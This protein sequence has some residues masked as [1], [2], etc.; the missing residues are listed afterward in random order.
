M[1]G[2]E[3][4]ELLKTGKAISDGEKIYKY[5]QNALKE[6]KLYQTHKWILSESFNLNEDYTEY[7]LQPTGWHSIGDGDFFTVSYADDVVFMHSHRADGFGDEDRFTT[8]E[9]AE[10]IRFKNKLLR[11]LQRFSD[12]NCP[13]E[14]D[15]TGLTT[16]YTI[17]YDH[18]S[19]VPLVNIDVTSY[20]EVG[21]VYFSSSEVASR[22]IQ[23]FKPEL[24]KYFTNN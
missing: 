1:N 13:N 9:M 2:I 17:R 3:A 4:I 24:I 5:E 8:R 15:L 11:K 7:D 12:E 21:Q 6:T 23:K 16:K 14:L 18:V 20:Q 22:A 19:G 10:K